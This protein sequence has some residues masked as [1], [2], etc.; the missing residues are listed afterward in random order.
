MPRTAESL[1]QTTICKQKQI[2]HQLLGAA[3]R[4]DDCLLL[5]LAAEGPL[6][7]GNLP[8]LQPNALYITCR[9][10][11]QLLGTARKGDD[12]CDWPLE[13]LKGLSAAECCHCPGAPPDAQNSERISL[14]RATA[15]R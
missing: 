9:M 15:A 7:D 2:A 8:P 11:H 6:C 5:L 4:S 13:L 12:C 1:N 3:C 10:L 14:K